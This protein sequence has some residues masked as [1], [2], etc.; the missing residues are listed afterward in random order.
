MAFAS[1]NTWRYLVSFLHCAP[2]SKLSPFFS[3]V[4]DE[5]DE[6]ELEL[7]DDDELEDEEELDEE[8]D[9]ELDDDEDELDDDDPENI[10]AV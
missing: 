4:V 3:G 2:C 1:R 8:L 9:D 6:L 7:E 10:F 5:R